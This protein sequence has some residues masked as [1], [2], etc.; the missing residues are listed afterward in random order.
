MKIYLKNKKYAIKRI[1]RELEGILHTEDS[2][3][4]SDK[5]PITENW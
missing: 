5:A 4:A 1:A 3:K 2:D